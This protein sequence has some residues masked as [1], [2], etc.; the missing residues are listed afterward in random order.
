M[1]ARV[2]AVLR[3][4]RCCALLRLNYQ[5]GLE[6]REC[7]TNLTDLLVLRNVRL[8]EMFV[9]DLLFRGDHSDVGNCTAICAVRKVLVKSNCNE[10]S[11]C[12]NLHVR[13]DSVHI[14]AVAGDGRT[15]DYS[16]AKFE[17]SVLHIFDVMFDSSIS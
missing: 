16:V 13:N 11:F 10:E 7:F 9:G 8:R 12:E 4:I 5:E 14:L 2:A 6:F 15:Y 3:F 1:T 17:F